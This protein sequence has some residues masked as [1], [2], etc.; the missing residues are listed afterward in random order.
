MVYREIIDSSPVTIPFAY[1]ELSKPAFAA[2]MLLMTF[3]DSELIGQGNVAKRLGYKSRH[4]VEILQELK[5]YGYIQI[6]EPKNIGDFSEVIIVKRAKVSGP[7]RFV[8]LSNFHLSE[9]SDDE[10]VSRP[11]SIESFDGKLEK[12]PRLFQVLKKEQ[13]QMERKMLDQQTADSSADGAESIDDAFTEGYQPTGLGGCITT[14]GIVGKTVPK[15][16][17]RVIIC[18]EVEGAERL[19]TEGRKDTHVRKNNPQGKANAYGSKSLNLNAESSNGSNLYA[20]SSNGDERETSRDDKDNMVEKKSKTNNKMDVSKFRKNLEDIKRERSQRAKEG[21][22]KRLQ[23]KKERHKTKLTLDWTK[24]DARG[25]PEVSFSPSAKTRKKLIAILDRPKSDPSRQ[26]IVEK[27]T[28][29]FG[30][31]YSRYRRMVQKASGNKP[32]YLLPV[33]ER[34]FVER[35]AILCIQKSVTPRAVLTYWHHHIDQFAD[36]NMEIPPLVFLSSPANI[37]TVVCA[38]WE[39]GSV[40]WNSGQPKIESNVGHSFSDLRQL[41]PR[42]RKALSKAGFA[43]N[44]FDDRYLLTIQRMAE[45]VA[46]GLNVFISASVKPI[47]DWAATNLYGGE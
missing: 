2:W 16:R 19:A 22:K 24:L 28:S 8:T 38:E 29:E 17:R 14:V 25:K 4:G 20:N 40:G 21:A 12:K 31:L 1:N 23:K 9:M 6:T 44:T 26:A 47:V 18:D 27:L 45:T 36:A 37:E 13:P 11:I 46:L 5:R 32:G 30:R 35:A 34:R 33:T 41:D 42:L 3:K 15:T 39:T 10:L 7:N 43:V